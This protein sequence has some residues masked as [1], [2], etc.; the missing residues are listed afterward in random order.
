MPALPDLSANAGRQHHLAD[1]QWAGFLPE[2]FQ[3]IREQSFTDWELVIVDDGSTDD[4]QQL[5][6]QLMASCPQ[7]IR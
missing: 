3:S 6:D 4:T 2:A 5:V 1:L 7:R